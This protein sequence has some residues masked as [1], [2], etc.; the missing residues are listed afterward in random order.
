MN[1]QDVRQ[2]FA[3]KI[4]EVEA[5]VP[6]EKREAFLGKVTDVLTEAAGLEGRQAVGKFFG[7]RLKELEREF[8]TPMQPDA[9]PS[10]SK[11][12]KLGAL[13]KARVVTPARMHE[14][15]QC[16]LMGVPG[17]GKAIESAY[18]QLVSGEGPVSAYSAIEGFIFEHTR[19]EIAKRL[20]H[21]RSLRAGGPITVSYVGVRN[22][23]ARTLD[24]RIDNDVPLI[25]G[26]IWETKRYTR[27]DLGTRDE[28]YN[29]LLKYQA[30]IDQKYFTGATLEVYGNIS[31]RFLRALIDLAPLAPGLHL[32][33]PDVEVLYVV[34]NDTAVPLRRSRASRS[35]ARGSEAA[36]APY[37]RALAEKRYGLFSGRIVTAH[38]LGRGSA[39]L[40][41]CLDRSGLS[42]LPDELH[43]GGS[44]APLTVNPE[45]ITDVELFREFERVLLKKRQVM[46][47][48]C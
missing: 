19:R 48:D 42:G 37:V 7:P 15:L 12:E 11:E 28:V 41:A 34:D 40:R 47:K 17:V 8:A 44:M 36:A 23:E 46:L 38:D 13:V 5:R 14:L 27:H 21:G 1:Q 9:P 30:A 26:H 6:L 24:S 31:P 32:E 39:E 10:L 18:G 2:M 35:L 25:P 43:V 4:Q 33:V 20:G 45:R 29:Q 3:S 22:G 16:S